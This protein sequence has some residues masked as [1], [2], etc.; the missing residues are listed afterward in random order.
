MASRSYGKPF[1]WGRNI[2][3]ITQRF[4]YHR[5]NALRQALAR[6]R[7]NTPTKTKIHQHAS[8]FTTEHA[9]FSDMGEHFYGDV[10][11][12]KLPKGSIIIIPK[13]CSNLLHKIIDFYSIFI[14][15]LRKKMHFSEY[16]SRFA[17]FF[18][19]NKYTQKRFFRAAPHAL[20]SHWSLQQFFK[21]L[22]VDQ[23]AKVSLAR[24]TES[25][26]RKNNK[27]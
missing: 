18:D 19:F 25:H 14:E 5:P 10:I 21:F 26:G 12:C 24:K 11:F 23:Y 20:R 8:F 3:Q 13:V 4:N 17:R 22:H 9:F 2:F 7:S 16:F 15:I 27:K 6:Y 1:L